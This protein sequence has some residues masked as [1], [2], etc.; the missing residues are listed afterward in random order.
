[1][2]AAGTKG[3]DGAVL[4]RVLARAATAWSVV[5]LVIYP[6]VIDAQE[7]EI[8]WRYVVLIVLAALSFAFAALGDWARAV[9]S[10]GQQ[11][12]C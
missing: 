8:V 7:G 2:V 1:V 3:H 10:V 11:A 5:Y 4:P 12:P 6:W 9:L